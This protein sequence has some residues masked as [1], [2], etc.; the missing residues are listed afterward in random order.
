MYAYNLY[1]KEFI[2]R[3]VAGSI[4]DEVTRYKIDLILPAALSTWSRQPL[5]GKS[6]RNVPGGTGCVM[7]TT[8]PSVSRL[9]RKCG[10]LE[11]SQLFG[12]PWPV[13]RLILLFTCRSIMYFNFVLVI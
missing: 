2:R 1:N 12:S 9:C 7:F 10:S 6:T 11:V 3:K 8:S 5:M 13:T 4:T